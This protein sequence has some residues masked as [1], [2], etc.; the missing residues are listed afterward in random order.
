MDIEFQQEIIDRTFNRPTQ[1][2]SNECA[3]IAVQILHVYLDSIVNHYL[4]HQQ[5][6]LLKYKIGELFG[7]LDN[8]D[9]FDLFNL[10]MYVECTLD[11]W[12]PVAIEYE[13]YEGIVNLKKLREL[14]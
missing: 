6:L 13:K 2:K 8:I 14:V 5:L 1:I 9:P 12:E 3:S 7:T 10:W 4:S 11:K